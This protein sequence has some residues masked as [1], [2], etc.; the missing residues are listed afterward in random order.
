ML[1]ILTVLLPLLATTFVVHAEDVSQL[2]ASSNNG[3]LNL[4][5]TIVFESR[6]GNA[7]AKCMPWSVPEAQRCRYVKDHRILCGDSN[8]I[9]GYL[10]NHYC[11]F[12]RWYADNV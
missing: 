12:G 6:S 11:Y 1:P 3:V 9:I 8:G 4:V 2:P 10:H 5:S 7:S